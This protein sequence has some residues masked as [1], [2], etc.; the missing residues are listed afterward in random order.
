MENEKLALE[1]ADWAFFIGA[2]ID[3]QYR[4]YDVMLSI[5]AAAAGSETAKALQ[6]M[7]YNSEFLYPPPFMT[8]GEDQAPE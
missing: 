6:E 5:L 2:M 8:D 1:D 7:H 4:I 3:S